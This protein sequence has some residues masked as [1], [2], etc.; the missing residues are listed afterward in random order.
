[1]FIR[2]EYLT[3]QNRSQISLV[4]SKCC[5]KKNFIQI[6]RKVKKE[7]QDV[8]ACFDQGYIREHR[9]CYLMDKIR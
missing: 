1:M 9:Q 4:L 8:Y 5:F 3:L 2:N 6:K 7:V